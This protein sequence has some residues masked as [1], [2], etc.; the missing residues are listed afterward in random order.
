M[1]QY[2]DRITGTECVYNITIIYKGLK[3]FWQN[4][5]TNI[6]ID[7]IILSFYKQTYTL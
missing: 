5:L 3:A 1:L 4:I 7:F 2:N 6:N